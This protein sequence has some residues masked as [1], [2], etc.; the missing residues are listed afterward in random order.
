[1]PTVN[2]RANYF[3][4]QEFQARF[5]LKFCALIIAACLMMG[6]MV[7]FFST[8][9]ITASFENLSFVARS[10]ANFILP[11]LIFSTLIAAIIIS[12]SCIA[13]V[14]FISHRIAGP[15]YHIERSI[16]AIAKGDLTID[17]TLRSSDE[18]K[19]MADR[20]NDMVKKIRTAVDASGEDI[21]AIE[22]ALVSIR[23][24]LNKED[25]P[26]DRIN[27]ITDPARIQLE[28]LKDDMSYFKLNT[29]KGEAS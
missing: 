12:L 5:I 3:I 26:Q 6:I 4:K 9:T 1:M 20:L 25:I 2:R 16:S 15:L 7:Y 14:L 29:R 19:V 10:T 27:R 28:K 23:E 11:T 13:V 18:I 21:K 8:R 22:S 17:T 24:E